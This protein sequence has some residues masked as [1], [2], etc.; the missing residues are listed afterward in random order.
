MYSQQSSELH[1]VRLLEDGANNAVEAGQVAVGGARGRAVGEG[2]AGQ[3][4][5]DKRQR[6]K[7]EYATTVKHANSVKRAW[8]EKVT[9]ADGANQVLLSCESNLPRFSGRRTDKPVVRF[10]VNIAI[11]FL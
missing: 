9:K 6:L 4:H 7:N 8:H 10:I 5:E 2:E 1:L 3:A 11:S